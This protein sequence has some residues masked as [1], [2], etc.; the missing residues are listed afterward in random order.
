MTVAARSSVTR[1]S[2]RSIAALLLRTSP[3]RSPSVVEEASST[4]SLASR[5]SNA[6]ARRCRSH[7]AQDRRRLPDAWRKSSRSRRRRGRA[8]SRHQQCPKCSRFRRRIR[9]V[10]R[11]PTAA[12]RAPHRWR[13]R[14]NATRN[15]PRPRAPP[16]PPRPSRRA[17][18]DRRLSARELGLRR[19]A[20]SPLTHARS[21]RYRVRVGRGQWPPP[22]W[23]Y[24]YWAASLP[25]RPRAQE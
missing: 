18:R 16:R 17:W 19:C 7:A 1:E 24:A 13:R 14:E 21:R 9:A 3:P 2:R 20:G 11:R 12:L 6:G 4:C 10:M 22:S 15:P 5:R 25:A 23:N 8:R